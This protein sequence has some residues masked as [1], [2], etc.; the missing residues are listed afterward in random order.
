MKTRTRHHCKLL[1]ARRSISLP[2]SHSCLIAHSTSSQLL[3][4]FPRLE[5]SQNLWNINHFA[6][7]CRVS[8]YDINVSRFSR[9]EN[10]IS[11]RKITLSWI[12]FSLI[13]RH[14][15]RNEICRMRCHVRTWICENLRRFRWRNSHRTQGCAPS[16]LSRRFMKRN[17]RKL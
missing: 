10:P 15:F 12:T 11:Y 3:A 13:N 16:P 5:D 2:L 1:S 17:T 6:L 7:D 4:H 9:Y 8:F 14:Q